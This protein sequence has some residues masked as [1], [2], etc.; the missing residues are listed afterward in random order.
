[1]FVLGAIFVCLLCFAL[2]TSKCLEFTI[3]V[4]YTHEKFQFSWNRKSDRVYVAEIGMADSKKFTL[5]PNDV[6]D[7]PKWLRTLEHEVADIQMTIKN[8][9]EKT[10]FYCLNSVFLIG[11]KWKQDVEMWSK[12]EWNRYKLEEVKDNSAEFT[13]EE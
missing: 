5:I 11:M 6:R 4:Q 10:E 13:Q 1:M 12:P 3:D 8:Y 9:R 7:F 2:E